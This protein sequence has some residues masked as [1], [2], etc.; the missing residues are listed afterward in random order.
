MSIKQKTI[1]GI[2]WAALQNWGSQ[3]A[4]LLIFLIMARLLAPESFGLVALANS[5]L[6]FVNILIDQGLTTALVQRP[7][8]EFKHLNSVFWTQ[9]ALGLF[10]AF[11]GFTCAPTIAAFFKEPLLEL[12]IRAFSWLPFIESFKMVHLAIFRRQLA[13]KK[14]AMRVLIG[15]FSSGVIGVFLALNG[16]GVWSIVGQQITF[17]TVGVVVFWQLSDWRPKLTFSLRHLK[18]LYGFGFSTLSYRV[19]TYLNQ[20]TDTLLIGYFLG[21]VAL[22]YYAVAYRVFQVLTQLLVDTPNQVVFPVFSRLQQD[23]DRLTNVFF[24]AIQFSSLIAFPMLFGVISLARELVLTIFGNQW[25]L[26]IPLMQILSIGGIVYFILLFNQSVFIALGYPS[27]NMRLE[28][29]NCIFNILLCAVAVQWGVLAVACAYIVSDLLVIPASLWVLRESMAISLTGYAV[30]LLIPLTYSAAMMA[31]I[32][33]V[34]NLMLASLSPLWMLPIYTFVGGV[35]Y[36]VL[37]FTFTP[38]LF[39]ELWSFRGFLSKNKL[40]A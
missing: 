37:V 4:A 34:K 39:Y 18:E 28:A 27:W 2:A 6:A 11:V 16:F 13:F 10:F 38:N 1:Q 21:S 20:N 32:L 5:F 40:K 30:R 8:I 15:I 19:L 29:L 14:I 3:I 23:L 25:Y 17:E 12:I 36:A 24:K 31:V 35:F 26:S 22:G 9:T 7:H 33:L